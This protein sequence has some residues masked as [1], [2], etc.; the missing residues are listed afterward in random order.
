MRKLFCIFAAVLVALSAAAL[1]VTVSAKSAKPKSTVITSIIASSPTSVALKWKKVSGATS[2]KVYMATSKNGK[3]KLKKTTSALN[4]T[5]SGL[6]RGKRY[7]FRVRT[8][9]KKLLGAYSAKRAVKTPYLKKS[10]LADYS[11]IK[12]SGTGSALGLLPKAVSGA[13]G[14][15][16]YISTSL[17]GGYAYLGTAPDGN[18]WI[19]ANNL[20]PGRTYWIKTIPYITV[21][22]VRRNGPSQTTAVLS[23]P[24]TPVVTNVVALSD[25]SAKVYW[26]AEP[27]SDGMEVYHFESRENGKFYE[28][29]KDGATSSDTSYTVTWLTKGQTY[30][31]FLRSYCHY[32]SKHYG[33]PNMDSYA[34]VAWYIAPPT[35]SITGRNASGATV[36]F[37]GAA[38]GGY[39]IWRSAAKDG[40]YSLAAT[41]TNGALTYRDDSS[42]AFY[43]KVRGFDNVNGIKCYSDFSSAAY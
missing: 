17:S 34:F 37:S 7:W 21:N 6:S 15:D 8:A 40:V 16:L 5:V 38:T 39:E 29:I 26:N 3:Y 30:R 36:R 25:T 23:R 18:T 22:G 43:Y 41:V 12:S 4:Y 11:F 20:T 9:K 10:G 33:L 19:S 32:G 1:P 42:A 24:Y 13:E 28:A 2:Y 31:F 14:Y 27:S 35:V